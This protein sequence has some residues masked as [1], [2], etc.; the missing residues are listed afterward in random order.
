MKDIKEF[1]ESVDIEPGW[2]D[3]NTLGML[4]NQRE[5]VVL[6][7]QLIVLGVLLHE[8]YHWKYPGIMSEETIEKMA[9]NRINKMSIKQIM[10]TFNILMAI[11]GLKEEG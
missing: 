1:F 5:I 4:D 10:N 3:K 7:I 11:V 9:T 6:N 8:F 2:I